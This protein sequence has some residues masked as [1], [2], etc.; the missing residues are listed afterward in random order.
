VVVALEIIVEIMKLFQKELPSM[1][2]KYGPHFFQ[3]GYKF[4]NHWPIGGG[5]N[6]ELEKV[7]LISLDHRPPAKLNQKGIWLYGCFYH[8]I[9]ILCIYN[10]I[11]SLSFSRMLFVVCKKMDSNIDPLSLVANNAIK[12]HCLCSLMWES[13]TIHLTLNAQCTTFLM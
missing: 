8:N 5:V 3:Y 6:Y 12:H 4:F 2:C 11:Y 7:L 9:N 10:M 13:S 1:S